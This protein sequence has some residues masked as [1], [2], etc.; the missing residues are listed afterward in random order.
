MYGLRN[1]WFNFSNIP[2]EKQLVKIQEEL[3][4]LIKAIAGK[5]WETQDELWDV[6]LAVYWLSQILWL[7]YEETI[8]KSVIKVNKRLK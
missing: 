1:L 6:I 8:N 2:L 5:E 7:D 3:W 4:E